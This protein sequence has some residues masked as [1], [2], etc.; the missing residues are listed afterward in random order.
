[1]KV[2]QLLEY[3]KDANRDRKLVLF[4]DKKELHFLHQWIE[5]KQNIHENDDYN[6][7]T[8]SETI[9]RC[10]L[11]NDT[12]K[13]R[14][15]YGNGQNGVMII[16]NTP[17]IIDEIEKKSLEVESVD[18][19]K[20]ML[21]SIDL[22][23]KDSYTTNLIKCKV[24]NLLTKPS[25]MFKNCES[26]LEKEIISF[27]PQVIIVMGDRLPLRNITN[28]YTKISWS[29]IEHPM[30]LIKLPEQKREAWE[31]LKQVKSKLQNS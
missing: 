13:K 14:F 3:I 16:L 31:T 5:K 23:L 17:G 4:R 29:H 26:I 6:N 2:N 19:L 7:L 22:D 20:K 9:E 1:M 30:T 8:V 18:M 15:G 25:L 12:K 28:K 11:C 21:K 27:M 10:T 24:N